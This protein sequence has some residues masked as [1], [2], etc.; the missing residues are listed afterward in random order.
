MATRVRGDP[1]AQG[2]ARERAGWPS[3]QPEQSRPYP[4]PVLAVPCS[5]PVPTPGLPVLQHEALVATKELHLGHA[6]PIEV[7]DGVAP[8]PGPYIPPGTPLFTQR[9]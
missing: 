7:G 3:P 5:C 1:P 9:H 4:C 2:W 6:I 8:P